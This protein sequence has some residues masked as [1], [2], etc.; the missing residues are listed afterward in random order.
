MN[1]EPRRVTAI[2]GPN[3]AGKTTV[4]N[5][6][7]GYLHPD[8]GKIFYGSHDLTRLRPFEVARLG[9]ARS[10]QDVRVFSRM[11]VLENVVLAIQ[12]GDAERLVTVFTG[13]ARAQ[14]ER[15]RV[16]ALELL[17]RF[18]LLAQA[19]ELVGNLAYAQQ[20]LL[21]VATL[22]A[23]RDPLILLD[24]LAAGLDHASVAEFSTL[25]RQIASEGCT[26]CLIEHNLEF[27]FQTADTVL[28][29]DQGRL[30]AA[31]TPDEIKRD[32]RVAEI[33]FGQSGLAHA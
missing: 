15:A 8:K 19:D 29:L 16:R 14:Q 5:M 33:Y 17:E 11:T 1:I 32:R 2:I 24:E 30:L 10:F 31:G 22:A 21:V 7:T 12:G 6:L 3:G 4:F 26:V 18:G 9:I 23:R 13:R 28:V 20:K 25:V 27:V